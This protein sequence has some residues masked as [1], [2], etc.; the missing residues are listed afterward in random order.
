MLIQ[1]AALHA[2]NGTSRPTSGGRDF[3]NRFELISNKQC[4][5]HHWQIF[6]P[7]LLRLRAVATAPPVAAQ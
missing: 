7:K 6:L 1:F 2:M 4:K 5:I 3:T